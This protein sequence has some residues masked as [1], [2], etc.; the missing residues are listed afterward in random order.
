MVQFFQLGPKRRGVLNEALGES[1]GKG[2]ANFTNEY[3]AN[4]A[5]QGVLNDKSLDKAP[6]SEKMQRLQTALGMH[7]EA[8]QRQF[9]GALQA[10]MMQ[11]QEQQLAKQEQKSQEE[12]A[13]KQLA[14]KQGGYNRYD[15]PQVA[16]A[17]VKEAQKAAALEK[18][19]GMPPQ[20]MMPQQGALQ[21]QQVQ[22]PGQQTQSMPQPQ[23]PP[24]Q[25]PITPQVAPQPIAPQGV[26][27]PSAQQFQNPFASKSDDELIVAT[28]SPYE[29]I[30]RPAQ[31]ELDR[32]KLEKKE[33]EEN[34]RFEKKEISES[35]KTNSDYINKVYDQYEDSLR[36]EAIL[37]KITQ[38][39]ETGEVSESSLINA[40]HAL[41]ISEEFLRN[42]ANEELAKLSLDLLGGGSLQAD[43]GSR[44]L[45]SEFQTAM[46]RVPGLM[47]TKEGRRQIIENIKAM[48]LPS[49][50]KKERMQFY[51]DQ[52]D[53]TGKPLPNNLRG[54]VLQDIK[55]QLEEAYDKFKQRNGRYKVKS[56]TKLDENAVEK[57]Y[58]IS[59]GD[60]KKARMMMKEDGYAIE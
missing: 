26:A 8:G 53:R 12:E 54:K 7:G 4:K 23:M 33:S 28:G 50:L 56:G 14:A 9:T 10:A 20:Q 25:A 11:Q 32:R 45:Q 2:L 39:D 41:G 46:K 17:K 48:I 38:L 24:E 5:L 16:A 51:L 44:V 36:K 29:E 21:P 47:Q 52:S 43:Y 1:L 55:P 27:Q 18:F 31:A 30:K 57:Y 40:M 15:P 19:Y 35:Y 37:S 13:G 60:E 3:Y 49:L 6:L 34:K 59:N 58:I 42:P 22:I